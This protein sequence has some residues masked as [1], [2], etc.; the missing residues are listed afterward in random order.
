MHNVRHIVPVQGYIEINGL[1]NY[2]QN[3][4]N[5][6]MIN[7]IYISRQSK[8][9]NINNLVVILEITGK[10]LTHFLMNINIRF[11]HQYH[12]KMKEVMKQ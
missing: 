12:M 11:I 9:Q 1:N 10:E 8:Y 6:S 4:L 3:L 2:H 7:T 5:I